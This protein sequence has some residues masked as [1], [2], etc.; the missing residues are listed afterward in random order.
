MVNKAQDFSLERA[1]GF[2]VNRAAYLMSEGVAKRFGEAGFQLTAQDFGILFRLYQDDGLTQMQIADLMMR[3]KTTITR[4]L[5]GL[6]K[7]GLIERRTDAVDRRHVR[8][9]LSEVGRA[10]MPRLVAVVAY[11]QIEALTDVSDEEKQITINTLQKITAQ[12]TKG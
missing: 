1:V 4:R 2:F 12:L 7:K 3:D 9:H 8:I 6:V 10:S 5:D 11:F